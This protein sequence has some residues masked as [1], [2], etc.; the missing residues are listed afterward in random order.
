[1]E[2]LQVQSFILT[3]WKWQTTRETWHRCNNLQQIVE[4][5]SGFSDG[6]V[7]S[8]SKHG[9]KHYGLIEI[10]I[11]WPADSYKHHREDL[12]HEKWQTVE[13]H[14]MHI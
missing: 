3:T 13:L 10:R 12:K 6:P 7:A 2:S 11:S 5:C 9:N 14:H 8:S 4:V 1:M